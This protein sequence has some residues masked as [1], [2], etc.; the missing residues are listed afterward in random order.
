MAGHV[1]QSWRAVLRGQE[2]KVGGTGRG[3]RRNSWGGGKGSWRKQRLDAG[4]AM[5][6][7]ASWLPRGTGLTGENQEEGA[8][9]TG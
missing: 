3:P 6:C 9:A 8:G 2:G 1:G 7:R 4:G 5:G